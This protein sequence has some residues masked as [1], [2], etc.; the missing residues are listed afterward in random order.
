MYMFI[1]GFLVAVGVCSLVFVLTISK[2]YNSTYHNNN[3][4]ALNNAYN[5]TIN[6]GK[7]LVIISFTGAIAFLINHPKRPQWLR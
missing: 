6:L 2:V 7:P 4:Y 1:V 3:N 5:L